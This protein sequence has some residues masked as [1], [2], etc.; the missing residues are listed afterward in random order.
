MTD[1]S[2]RRGGLTVFVAAAPGAGK[3]FA[4]LEEGVRRRAAGQDVVVGLVETYDRPRTVAAIGDLE[5]L[6][7][8]AVGYKGMELQ[9]LDLEAILKRKPQAVLIDELYHTNPPGAAN[10]HRY[11]DVDQIRNAGIDVLT[12]MNIQHLESLKDIAEQIANIRVRETIPDR[13]LED[14]DELQLVDISPEALRKRMQHGNIYPEQN[15]ERALDGFFRPGN[16]AALRELALNWLANTEAGRTADDEQLPP[17]NVMA[18]IREPMASQGLIRR[19]LRMSRRYHG[20]CTILTVMRPG[21]TLSEEMEQAEKLAAACDANFEAMVDADAPHAIVDAVRRRGVTQLIVGAPGA[22]FLERYR[23]NFL[24]ELL[25]NLPEVDLHVI[26]RHDVSSDQK[27]SVTEVTTAAEQA[28]NE[29]PAADP[30]GTE[31]GKHGYLRIYIGYAPGCGTTATMLREGQRRSG[32]GTNVVV[33]SVATYG[34]PANE[35]ALSGLTVVPPRTAAEKPGGPADMDLD[36]VIASGAQVVCVDDIGY[37]NQA[38]DARFR[39]RY[40]EVEELRR[41]GFK[42]VSTVDLH[43][44]ESVAPRVQAETGLERQQRV[45][46]WML[47]QATELEL[48]DVPPA[49]LI[50]RLSQPDRTLSPERLERVRTIYTIDVLGRLREL[51]LRLVASHTDARLTAY[52][53]MIGITAPWESMTRVMACVAPVQGLEPLIERAARETR[54][55]EGKLIVVNV[56]PEGKQSPEKAAAADEV[57]ERYRLLALKVGGQF[58]TIKSNRT[59]QAL[60]DYAKRTHV[61]QLVLARRDRSAS[62]GFGQSIKKDI[63][64]EASQIDVHLLREVP[65]PAAVESG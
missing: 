58:V 21:E 61:T 12:T 56:E 8:R 36:A 1:P 65:V 64:R 18:A 39:Q 15:I 37:I 7:R 49:T 10:A 9:E 54:R 42:V 38:P 4:M 26:A 24:D 28:V 60:L 3:T 35:E 31:G 55:N 20:T 13:Y 5:I 16:L 32:R 44:V 59:A 33:G 51:A 52:M 25:D 30:V 40:E 19:A 17:E 14:A 22:R 29:A 11:E 46:D 62:G 6:P 34:L 53:D 2:G 45:P 41:Q 63:L 47:E 27:R 48:V 23:G 57:I 43:N 50:E